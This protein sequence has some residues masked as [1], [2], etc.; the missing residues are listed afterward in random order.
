MA[1][2]NG[3]HLLHRTIRHSPPDM[4]RTLERLGQKIISSS[5]HEYSAG[6]QVNFEVKDFISEALNLLQTTGKATDTD[7][8]PEEELPVEPDDLAAELGV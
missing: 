6:R 7:E 5:P 1:V 3:F 8:S 4:K 2:E